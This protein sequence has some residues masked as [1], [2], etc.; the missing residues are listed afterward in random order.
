MGPLLPI[1]Y[2]A[3]KLYSHIKNKDREI[4][5]GA[6]ANKQN[7][8]DMAQESRANRELARQN[9]QPAGRIGPAGMKMQGEVEQRNNMLFQSILDKYGGG[10]IRTGV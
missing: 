5:Q 4:E 1:G 10:G 7:L 8:I 6:A 3:Y 9:Y 2:G